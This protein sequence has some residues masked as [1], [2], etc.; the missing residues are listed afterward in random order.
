MD[1]QRWRADNQA[2]RQGLRFRE[3]CAGD[4]EAPSLDDPARGRPVP[5]DRHL[6]AIARHDE[7]DRVEVSAQG[8][9]QIR[10]RGNVPAGRG[11]GSRPCRSSSMIVQA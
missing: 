5:L 2:A 1:H 6:L 11:E 3:E 9:H 8:I 4:P 10:L 7:R